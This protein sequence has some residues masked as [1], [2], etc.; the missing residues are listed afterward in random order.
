MASR[1]ALGTAVTRERGPD[2]VVR[3]RA[4]SSDE[5]TSIDALARN[6][7]AQMLR[8]LLPVA[9]TSLERPGAAAGLGSSSRHGAHTGTRNVS[10]ARCEPGSV[11][12]TSA[13]GS[14][15]VSAIRASAAA[16]ASA[17]CGR[18]ASWSATSPARS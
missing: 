4:A 6:L 5:P 3:V 2:R 18:G 10:S 1:N 9:G 12:R 8:T 15:S 14:P 13:G 11:L 16:L 7:A 17:S